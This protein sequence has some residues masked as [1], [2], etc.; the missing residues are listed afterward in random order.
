MKAI[1]CCLAMY[2][3]VI[4]SACTSGQ[5]LSRYDLST[6]E[7]VNAARQAVSGRE[8]DQL[9]KGCVRRHQ[10]LPEIVMVGGFAHDLG[11]TMDGA[12]IGKRF[13]NADDNLSRNALEHLGWAKSDGRKREEIALNW[14]Q[15]G[16][17]AFEYPLASANGDF[18]KQRFDKPQAVTSEQTGVVV[19]SLWN[20]KPPGML[21][22]K[23]YDKFSYAFAKDGSLKEKSRLMG[24]TLP[25]KQ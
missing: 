23:N 11:C 2:L 8:I 14:V 18:T 19:V 16:L 25:C 7:G 17:L 24:F 3:V 6:D 22:E 20:Q 10:S 5:D 15:F 4:W 21:C 12:F 13:I 9:S 1:R